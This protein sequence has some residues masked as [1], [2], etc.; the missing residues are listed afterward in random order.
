MSAFC[1]FILQHQESSQL[2][3]TYHRVTNKQRNKCSK[4][5]SDIGKYEM[6]FLGPHNDLVIIYE[7][8]VIAIWGSCN[9]MGR[10]DYEFFTFRTIL[11][12]NVA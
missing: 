12:G 8:Y 9:A 7:L 3:N 4:T 6:T 1:S 11:K 2:S 5:K 10:S